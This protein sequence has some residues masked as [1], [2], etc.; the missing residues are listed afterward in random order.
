MMI[1]SRRCHAADE[2]T[3]TLNT[4]SPTRSGLPRWLARWLPIVALLVLYSVFLKWNFAP[5]VG[6]FDEHG[7]YV[8][9]SLLA[10][11]GETGLDLESRA[12]Y[13]GQHWFPTSAGRY[14][15]RHSPGLALLVAASWHLFGPNLGSTLS[16]A[17]NSV[18]SLLALLGTFLLVRKILGHWW[19]L[20]ATLLLAAGRTF[21][22]HALAGDAHMLVTALLVWGIYLLVLWSSGGRIVHVFLAGLLL[23]S[24]PMARAPEA[25]YVV[26]IALFLGMHWRARPRMWRHCLAAV[27]GAAV[28]AVPLLI[29]NH[30]CFG[31]FWRTA[32]ALTGEQ[33]AFSLGNLRMHFA[34]YLRALMGNAGLGLFFPLGLAGAVTMLAR[35]RGRSLGLAILGITVPTTLLYM[36]Y[37]WAPRTEPTL[38]MRFLLPVFTLLILSGLWLLACVLRGLRPWARVAVVSGLVGLHLLYVV[39]AS[40]E[41]SRATFN[42]KSVLAAAGRGVDA[43]VPHGSVVMTNPGLLAHLDFLRRW[44]LADPMLAWGVPARDASRAAPDGPGMLDESGK[45]RYWRFGPDE[46]CRVFRNDVMAW[47]AGAPVYF[48]GPESQAKSALEALEYPPTFVVIGRIPM[49][50]FAPVPDF[51]PLGALLRRLAGAT[52]GRSRVATRS[53]TAP[54][55]MEDLVVVE[56][57]DHNP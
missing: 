23:G 12:Q 33:S 5:A 43:A 40:L 11:T 14:Y 32:Y 54:T 31:A 4:D 55:P 21:S 44:R 48:V 35:A 2:G 27:A 49:P 3:Q 39:P 17:I 38:I 8:Q 53:R 45:Q 16:F 41:G 25:I 7:Y 19:G 22:T 1:R 18:L 28:P 46:S 10:T 34:Q 50:S 36:A 13:V 42:H 52:S 15:S 37:Y 6:A 47:S 24:I 30:L 29:H 57:R 51:D 56:I 26:G 9:G 20:A